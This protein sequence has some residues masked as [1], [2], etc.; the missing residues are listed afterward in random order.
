MVP[1]SQMIEA[2][3]SQTLKNMEQALDILQSWHTFDLWLMGWSCAENCN[4]ECMQKQ[5]LP[6]LQNPEK[7]ITNGEE[8][9][10]FFGKWPFRRVFG[11]QEFFSTLFS[12]FNFIP[13][14]QYFWV[15]Q[16]LLPETYFMHG[17][18][19][20]YTISGMNTWVW[21]TAFHAR[22]NIFTE[23]L[24]YFCATFSILVLL[25]IAIM[26]IFYL[27]QFKQKLIT[28]IPTIIYFS[29]HCYTLHYVHFDYGWNMMMMVIFGSVYC[30]LWYAWCFTHPDAPH[31]WKIAVANTVILFMSGFEVFDF[32]PL[33]QLLDAHAIW[34]FST[35]MC[36][37]LTFS[38]AIDDAQYL[39]EINMRSKEF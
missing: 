6:I 26:R 13:F 28:I 17:V 14:Y 31:R 30:L 22:D 5:T 35:P 23:R 8:V 36:T 38:F 11:I 32:P 21:S 9:V 34:H 12:I 29:W 19:Y 27:K 10:K 39:H 3:H 15:I 1:P 33:W 2:I 37:Y 20:F 7:S 4:Y 18:F 16:D 25:N 24:D